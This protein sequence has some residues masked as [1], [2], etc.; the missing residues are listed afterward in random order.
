MKTPR[1]HRNITLVDTT[2]AIQVQNALAGLWC[3]R[4]DPEGGWLIPST[5][6]L[7]RLGNA[8]AREIQKRTV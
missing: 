4:E 5:D 2:L 8:L 1:P 3:E 6:E 7:L